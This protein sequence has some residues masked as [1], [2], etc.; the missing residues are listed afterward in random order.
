MFFFRYVV[1]KKFIKKGQLIIEELPVVR[2]PP[3]STKPICLGCYEYLDK[4]NVYYCPKCHWPMCSKECC[5]KPDHKAECE[6]FSQSGYKVLSKKFN[7]QSFEPLYD[8]LTPIRMLALKNERPDDWKSLSS[9]Q[10]HLQ[11]QAWIWIQ[12]VPYMKHVKFDFFLFLV[13]FFPILLPKF[14]QNW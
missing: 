8:V 4:G 2:C 12:S 14:L 3:Y 5:S 9:L 13:D 11:G 10:S 6:I 7:Y 1:A